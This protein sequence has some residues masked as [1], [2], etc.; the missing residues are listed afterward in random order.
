[1]H[2]VFLLCFFPHSHEMR[3]PLLVL[4]RMSSP[5]L[6]FPCLI[7]PYLKVEIYKFMICSAVYS[8]RIAP[9]FSSRKLDADAS[10]SHK[11]RCLTIQ[12]LHVQFSK[13]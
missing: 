3:F 13:S 1:M 2:T 6:F 10:D 7:R 4:D 11:I 8:G 9:Y 12:A 5:Y